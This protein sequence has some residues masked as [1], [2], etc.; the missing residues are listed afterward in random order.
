MFNESKK[1]MTAISQYCGNRVDYVQGGGGNTSYK[2]NDK[3]M[4]IKASGYTLADVQPEQG[5]VTVDYSKISRKYDEISKKMDIDVEAET[6]LINL[7]CVELLH[8]M[9]DL[10]PSVEVGFHSYLQKAVIHTHSVYSNLLCCSDEGRDNA[11]SIF[12]NSKYGYIYIPFI[13]PGYTLSIRVKDEVIA[14][15]AENGKMPDL[16]FMESHGMIASNDDYETA[17][18]IHETANQMMIDYF[19]SVEFPKAIIKKTSKGFSSK[20]EM[21][22]KFIVDFSADENYF[23]TV[24]IYPDQIVYLQNNLGKTI[25]IDKDNASIEYIMSEKQAQTLE[26][27]LLGVV[28]IITEIKRNELSLK[29]LCKEGEDFIRNW[30]SEKYRASLVND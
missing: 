13:S 21:I 6:L 10:R 3:L 28:Y 17:I 8:G 26:E 5:Y 15:K 19:N 9:K 25:L 30:E 1:A 11:K 12:E 23:D 27:V 7:D 29:L 22:N 18:E 24:N 20:T 2:F 4:A 16:I 14:Y